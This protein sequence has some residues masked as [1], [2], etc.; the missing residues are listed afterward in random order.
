MTEEMKRDGYV[1]EC[2]K[3]GACTH[4]PVHPQVHRALQSVQ[5][6]STFPV[7]TA[8]VGHLKGLGAAIFQTCLVRPLG[9]QSLT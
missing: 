7:I 4:A 9:L 8:E 1:P 2:P 3:P 6:Y 5:I